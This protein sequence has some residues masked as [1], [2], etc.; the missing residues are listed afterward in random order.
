TLQTLQRTIP[1]VGLGVLNSHPG[2]ANLIWD[3]DDQIAIASCGSIHERGQL[4]PFS[5]SSS[6]RLLAQDPVG[7]LRQ[8]DGS[9]AL[10]VYDRARQ[11]LTLSVDRFGF[12]PL[13]YSLFD[14][15]ILF[16]SEIKAILQARPAGVDWA[17]LA[18]FFYI[19]HMLGNATH[20]SGIHVLGPGE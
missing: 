14:G 18:E 5:A 7:V 13:Y 4:G 9:F 6:F 19:G 10:A 12:M 8:M 17:S 20:F 11:L 15:G 1:G 3:S 2:N 16:A